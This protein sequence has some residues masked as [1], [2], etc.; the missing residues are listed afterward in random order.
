MC[1]ITPGLCA[2]ICPFKSQEPQTWK[3]SWIVMLSVLVKC[4]KFNVNRFGVNRLEAAIKA[5]FTIKAPHSNHL[6]HWSIS[7]HSTE[8]CLPHSTKAFFVINIDSIH[9]SACNSICTQRTKWTLTV[10]NCSRHEEHWKETNVTSVWCMRVTSWP[11]YVTLDFDV[12]DD[13]WTATIHHTHPMWQV[14]M[15]INA[16]DTSQI[17]QQIAL[18]PN[19]DIK[20]IIGTTFTKPIKDQTSLSRISW[21]FN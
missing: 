18:A 14:D 16:C 9:C 4:D 8:H 11:G 21:W 3:L 1:C 15:D 17:S 19:N 13:W 20:L 5:P 7:I 6:R 2:P 10:G 12:G